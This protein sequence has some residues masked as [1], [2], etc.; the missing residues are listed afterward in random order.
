MRK[1]FL[2]VAVL[3]ISYGSTQWFVTTKRLC[4]IIFIPIGNFPTTSLQKVANYYEQTLGVHIDITPPIPIDESMIDRTREQLTGEELINQMRL[5]FPVQTENQRVMMMGF[6]RGDMYIRHKDWRFAF[7][8]RENGR[9]AAV[10]TARMDPES[11]GLPPND[12]VLVH[13][14]IKITSKQIG[15]YFYGLPERQEK[16]SVLFSP[17]LGVDDLDAVS[18][19]FDVI[20]RERMGQTARRCYPWWTE[21]FLP[22][23]AT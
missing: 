11:F 9:F 3:A 12:A 4:Q 6:V 10:S 5:H 13:R 8:Y 18:M 15:L 17:I 7:A 16:T 14:L 23:M 22:F 20:D 21:Y 2:I 19:D 1:V